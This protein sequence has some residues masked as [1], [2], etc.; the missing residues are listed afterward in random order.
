[1]E[2]TNRGQQREQWVEVT[3]TNSDTERAANREWMTPHRVEILE[4]TRDEKRATNTHRRSEKLPVKGC[5]EWG[6]SSKHWYEP[7]SGAAKM[8]KEWEE[9]SQPKH[10]TFICSAVYLLYSNLALLQ[11]HVEQDIFSVKTCNTIQWQM[12]DQD[13]N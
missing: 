7:E 8:C 9:R 13:N 12:I 3:D 4:R 2:L 1:M 11:V 6:E 5:K 10:K